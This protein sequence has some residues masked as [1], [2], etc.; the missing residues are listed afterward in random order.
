MINLDDSDF[1][2]FIE[3]IDPN[4]KTPFVQIKKHDHAN[5][6]YIHRPPYSQYNQPTVKGSV[7]AKED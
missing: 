6:Y 7:A 5:T 3:V 1:G 2:G 4:L